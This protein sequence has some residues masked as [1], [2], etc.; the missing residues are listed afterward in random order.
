M[1]DE[2]Y[3]HYTAQLLDPAVDIAFISACNPR[4]RLLVVYVFRRE[5]FPWV[6]NWEERNNRTVAPWKGNTFCRGMEFS[7]TPFAISRRETIDQGPLFGEITYRWLPA[8]SSLTVRYLIMLFM[9][10]EHFAGVSRVS[11]ER[12]R[13]LVIEAAPGN[14]QLSLASAFRL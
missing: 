9:T 8:R 3:G 6:G 11:I 14:R 1:P 12:G 7:T 2:S 10:P 5:D 13:A 4:L